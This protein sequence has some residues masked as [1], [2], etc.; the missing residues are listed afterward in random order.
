MHSWKSAVKSDILDLV[1]TQLILGSELT[2]TP[3]KMAVI[4]D[5]MAEAVK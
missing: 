4:L 3:K 5:F 2:P 1:R